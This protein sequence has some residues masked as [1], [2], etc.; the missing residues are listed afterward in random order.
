MGTDPRKGAMRDNQRHSIER[1]DPLLRDLVGWG[2]VERQAGNA[3]RWQLTPAAQQRLNE[4]VPSVAVAADIYLDRVCP[5]C[6]ERRLT[7]RHGDSYLCD[8]CW[9]DRQTR[10]S[11]VATEALAPAKQTHFR[12]RSRSRQ[13][14][15]E[16]S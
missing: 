16:A 8:R 12:R 5:D 7:R 6:H 14:N 11:V 1:F 3:K 13:G 4:L 15:Q 10:L 9:A 2:L